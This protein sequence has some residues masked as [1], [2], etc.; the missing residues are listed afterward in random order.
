MHLCHLKLSLSDLPRVTQHLCG[1]AGITPRFLQPYP[2]SVTAEN[3]QHLSLHYGKQRTGIK[4]T[5]GE[6]TCSFHP[7]PGQFEVAVANTKPLHMQG[8]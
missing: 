8:R 1:G 5:G 3:S 7:A 2:N 6:F 4:R